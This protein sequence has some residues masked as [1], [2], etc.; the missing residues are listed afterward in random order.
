MK[1]LNNETVILYKIIYFHLFIS[2]IFMVCFIALDLN[3][4]L[5]CAQLRPVQ[6]GWRCRRGNH[7]NHGNYNNNN[8]NSNYNYNNS[9]NYN[10]NNDDNNNNYII[11]GDGWAGEHWPDQ[12]G[13]R[14]P[15]SRQR[16]HA[17]EYEG[18]NHTLLLE[19]WRYWISIYSNYG[20]KGRHY[21]KRSFPGVKEK[22]CFS[23][24]F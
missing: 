14:A 6:Q 23:R 13:Q 11:P 3:A 4:A 24:I 17:Q 2:L 20:T 9:N 8:N 5:C 10:D 21:Q 1:S 12:H 15:P 19:V 22:L 16:D 7:I 18:N